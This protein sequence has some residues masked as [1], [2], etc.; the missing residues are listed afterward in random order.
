MLSIRVGLLWCQQYV[1]FQL[2]RD[3]QPMVN[4]VC[5][6]SY[7]P[8]NIFLFARIALEGGGGSL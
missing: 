4:E 7:D 6:N 1:Q 2:I 3:V 5:P 8:A